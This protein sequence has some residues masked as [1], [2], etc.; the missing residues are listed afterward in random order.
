MTRAYQLLRDYTQV[1]IQCSIG[2]DNTSI[3][4]M[5]AVAKNV[6]ADLI[7]VNN[8]KETQPTGWINRLLGKYVYKESSIPILTVDGTS[9][10]I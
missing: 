5:L 9:T 8:G 6:K 7:V 1:N 2:A 3:E 10:K 4:D